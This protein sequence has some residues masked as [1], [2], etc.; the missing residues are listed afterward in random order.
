LAWH[1]APMRTRPPPRE[2]VEKRSKKVTHLLHWGNFGGS[3]AAPLGGPAGAY[4]VSR[5]SSTGG[6]PRVVLYILKFSTIAGEF[7]SW[8][9]SGMEGTVSFAQHG[10]KGVIF[11][12]L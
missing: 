7:A 1:L 9:E 3:L 8:K 11:V 10:P 4:R 5:E 12:V 2:G 6:L